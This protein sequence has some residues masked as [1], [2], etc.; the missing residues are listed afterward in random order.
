LGQA[1]TRPLP[2]AAR[3]LGAI[4]EK[5][6]DGLLVTSPENVRY[7]SGFTGSEG[8]VLLGTKKRLF[9][10]DGRYTAQ[11]EKEVE[12]FR[13]GEYRLRLDGVSLWAKKLDVLRLGFED[14]HVS[15]HE[16]RELKKRCP[17]V[18]L[19]PMSKLMRRLRVA[20][21]AQETSRIRKAARI[22][23][24]SFEE[25]VA[26]IRP[27]MKEREIA[28]D[29]EFG[30]KRRG[31]EGIPFPIIVASG[32]RAA[33]PHGIATEKKIAKGDL[34][35]VDFGAVYGGYCSDETVTVVVGKPT[36]RQRR[37]YDTVREAHDRAISAIKPGRSLREVDAAARDFI[38]EAGYGDYFRHGTGHGVGLAVHEEPRI[39][40]ETTGTAEEGMVV[41]IEPGVYIPGW[42]GVRIEDMLRVTR[43]GCEILSGIPKE[44]MVV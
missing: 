2:R 10:T 19:I 23:S 28:L 7:L 11:A 24:A 15:F 31:A 17:K 18:S 35:T 22:A 16:H 39:S 41:T 30:M 9:L 20:K 6:L 34:V 5:K 37:V 29:L 26:K 27:G 8:V 40:P 38:K 44:L 1:S 14:E 43:R 42:G 32:R 3:L 12:G 25:T 33:L 4:K 21:E 36:R 13:L